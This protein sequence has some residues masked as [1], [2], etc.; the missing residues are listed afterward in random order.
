MSVVA[1]DVR[2][3]PLNNIPAS[4][5]ADT[6]ITSALGMATAYVNGVKREDATTEQIDNAVKTLGG[7]LSYLSYLGHQV[8]DVAGAF[9]DGYFT[10]SAGTEGIPLRSSHSDV[11]AKV[12]YLKQT[13]EMFLGL[14]SSVTDEGPQKPRRVPLSGTTYR[15]KDL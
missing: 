10:P 8:S 14:V 12:G 3:W 6:V 9:A 7:Y 5:I 4:D 13:A 2:I 1:D 11:K 15:Q